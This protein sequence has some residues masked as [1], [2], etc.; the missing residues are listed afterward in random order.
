MTRSDRCDYFKTL[1]TWKC[2]QLP[3]LCPPLLQAAVSMRS[4]PIFPL[5]P[6]WALRETLRCWVHDVGTGYGLTTDFLNVEVG[7]VTQTD[8]GL[9]LLPMRCLSPVPAFLYLGTGNWR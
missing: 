7:Q 5:A 4:K 9:S 3:E 8:L 2:S 1:A 6:S